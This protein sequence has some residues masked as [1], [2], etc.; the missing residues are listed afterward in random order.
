MSC[1]ARYYT[2][3]ALRM[4]VHS[5]FSSHASAIGDAVLHRQ[6]M[7]GILLLR[8]TF[9]AM[10]ISGP[11]VRKKPNAHNYDFYVSEIRI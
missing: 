6:N 3:A 11:S 9:C 5:L 1:C 7:D 2:T 8:S 10:L 4:H